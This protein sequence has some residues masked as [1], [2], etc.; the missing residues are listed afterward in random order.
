M[1]RYASASIARAGCHGTVPLGMPAK[2][3]L[4]AAQFHPAVGAAQRVAGK[5]KSFASTA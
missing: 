4:P 3:G 1:Q 2:H 5:T